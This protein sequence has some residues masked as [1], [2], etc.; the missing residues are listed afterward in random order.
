MYFITEDG[1][2]FDMSSTVVIGP[3]QGVS[4]NQFYNVHLI[5]GHHV[6]IRESYKS[7]SQFVTDWKGVP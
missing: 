5:N 7:R 2:E 6:T 4:P 3:L 1:E